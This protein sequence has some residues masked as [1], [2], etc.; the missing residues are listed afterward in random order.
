MYTNSTELFK[1]IWQLKDNSV[2]FNIKW[3]IIARAR[4]YNNTTKRC[5]LCLT[6]KVQQQQQSNIESC[7]LHFSYFELYFAL[8]SRVLSAFLE[9][10]V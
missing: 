8:H 10:L 3:S 6:V 7:V 5:D 2:N 4:P 1:Y 9:H